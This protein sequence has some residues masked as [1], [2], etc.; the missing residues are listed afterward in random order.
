VG[1]RQ[2]SG[3]SDIPVHTVQRSN[4]GFTFPRLKLHLLSA[5]V[6]PYGSSAGTMELGFASQGPLAVAN[7]C[8]EGL[9]PH[10]RNLSDRERPLIRS[11]NMKSSL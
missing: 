7:V 10:L 1:E 6:D 8:D 3:W 2:H 5:D 9:P 11:G 4:R